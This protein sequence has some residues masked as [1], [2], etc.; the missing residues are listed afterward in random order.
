MD[1]EPEVPPLVG[2]QLTHSERILANAGLSA[3]QDEARSLLGALLDTSTALLL[4]QP[5]RGMSL[6]EV[7][8]YATWVA[9]RAA[10]EAFAHITGHLAFMGLDITVGQQSPLPPPD[11]QRVVE[12]ALEWA[13]RSGLRELL[14][15]EIGVGCGAISLALAAFEPR[16]T[17]IYAIDSSAEALRI[18]SDNGARYLLNLVIHWVEGDDLDVIR[19]P[20]DLIISAHKEMAF[21]P[22]FTQLL[23]QAPAKVRS[24]GALMCSVDGASQAEVTAHLR[25]A[26]PGAQVYLSP[27]FDG[28]IVAVAQTLRH[29]AQ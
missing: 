22:R 1:G 12:T 5:D 4:A 24:G 21:T 18:A 7:E 23:K 29:P 11:A 6:L 17:R 25:G 16:F 9:R 26:L 20:V 2:P 10:G 13:R 8:A 28:T 3:P 15:A 19:E 27:R 14:A